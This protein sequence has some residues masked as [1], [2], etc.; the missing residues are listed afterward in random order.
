[1]FIIVLFQK[2][3]SWSL[4]TWNWKIE[5]IRKCDETGSAQI[6][7]SVCKKQRKIF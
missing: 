7:S 2:A 6:S 1:M 4:Y 3:Y 5:H